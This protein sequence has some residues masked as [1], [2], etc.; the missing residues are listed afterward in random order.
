MKE[1]QELIEILQFYGQNSDYV[2]A[3]GGNTSFKTA[4][5][6]WVKASGTTYE[7][8]KNKRIT[9]CFSNTHNKKSVES[10]SLSGLQGFHAYFI[11]QAIP[12]RNTRRSQTY[13]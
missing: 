9:D 12:R 7:G 4:D 11:K 5:R 13:S 3:G 2:I 6:L 8:L 10:I 1:I